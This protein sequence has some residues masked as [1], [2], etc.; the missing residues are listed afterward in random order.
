MPTKKKETPKKAMP[1]L[2]TDAKNPKIQMPSVMIRTADEFK[3]IWKGN[4]KAT[5][6]DEAW[7]RAEK[8]R[9]SYE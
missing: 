2:Y 6:L 9:D 7:S 3:A 4:V 1:K 5:D 8:W